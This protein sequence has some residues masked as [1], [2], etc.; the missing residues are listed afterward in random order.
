VEVLK[1]LRMSEGSVDADALAEMLREHDFPIERIEN[2]FDFDVLLR[3]LKEESEMG[4]V[5]EDEEL[6][7][8]SH[9]HGTQT[10]ILALQRVE[11]EVKGFNFLGMKFIV[12]SNF[13]ILEFVD[14]IIKFK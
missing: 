12:S 6:L 5:Y 3:F 14:S 4:D 10:E 8:F 2:D 13:K 1:K 11:V 9:A 7:M